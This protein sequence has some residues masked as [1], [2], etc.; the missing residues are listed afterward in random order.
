MTDRFIINYSTQQIKQWIDELD[1][2]STKQKKV[3]FKTVEALAKYVS[4]LPPTKLFDNVSKLVFE[5]GVDPRDIDLY[6]ID[7]NKN[8]HCITVNLSARYKASL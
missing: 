3:A 7:D 6:I 2:I 8:S 4:F 1:V 5:E